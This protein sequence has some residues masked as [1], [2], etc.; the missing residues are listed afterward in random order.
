M[1]Y[2]EYSV[3]I[4]CKEMSFGFIQTIYNCEAKLCFCCQF[5]PYPSPLLIL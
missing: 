4:F 1:P 5:C 2:W 3:V